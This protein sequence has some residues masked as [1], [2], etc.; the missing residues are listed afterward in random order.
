MRPPHIAFVSTVSHSAHWPSRRQGD[1]EVAAD[2]ETDVEVEVER[3]DKGGL[4]RRMGAGEGERIVLYMC[5]I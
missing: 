2:P 5:E 1:A 3:C 4:G